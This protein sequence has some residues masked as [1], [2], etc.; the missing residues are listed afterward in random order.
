[1]NRLIQLQTELQPQHTPK[2]RQKRHLRALS[3]K[4]VSLPYSDSLSRYSQAQAFNN[5]SAV[6]SA[7]IAVPTEYGD[8][9]DDLVAQPFLVNQNQEGNCG[10]AS[11]IMAL[12]NL[13][14]HRPNQQVAK[15]TAKQN[16]IRLLLDAIY[17]SRALQQQQ[18]QPYITISTYKQM[19]ATSKQ[20]NESRSGKAIV[21]SRIEKRLAHHPEISEIRDEQL[22][23]DYVLIV[24]LMLFFKDSVKKQQDQTLF[25]ELEDFNNRVHGAEFRGRHLKTMG[26]VESTQTGVK[27]GDYGL[28][29][30]G[31]T[32]LLQKMQFPNFKHYTDPSIATLRQTY[33][34]DKNFKQK[35]LAKFKD[36][37]SIDQSTNAP[38]ASLFNQENLKRFALSSNLSTKIK[39]AQLPWPCIVGIYAS[40]HYYKLDQQSNTKQF[41]RDL[42]EKNTKYNLLTHWVYMPDAE[43]VW[44]WG[45]E[46]NLNQIYSSG[47]TEDDIQEFI[48]IEVIAFG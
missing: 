3:K 32:H 8:R 16:E 28:P 24:G 40:D 35:V 39:W 38:K 45:Y 20:S 34:D 13:I 19:N 18:N 41:N 9:L 25:N 12:L 4:L 44:S 2:A 5:W 46:V 47:S 26:L 21:Q 10:F 7:Q 6:Q 11:A 22:I 17:T 33:K 37:I 31:L 14:E 27:K 15:T 36:D 1:M 48:P 23:A 43:T 42:F 29:V 30:N